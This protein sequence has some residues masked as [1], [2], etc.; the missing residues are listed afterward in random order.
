M[1]QSEEARGTAVA[2]SK[3]G[4]IALLYWLAFCYYA[5]PH[6]RARGGTTAAGR[7]AAVGGGA[8]SGGT[9]DATQKRLA[10][11]AT[12]TACDQKTL[13]L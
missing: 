10:F 4:C 8:G 12:A 1:L 3:S 6:A 9:L 11:D 2:L 5:A 7:A 13:L